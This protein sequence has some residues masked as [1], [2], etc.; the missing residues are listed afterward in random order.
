MDNDELLKALDQCYS[1]L[2]DEQ[3][4]GTYKGTK[5]L[6]VRTKLWDWI[7]VT[8]GGPFNKKLDKIVHLAQ[9]K[10][11]KGFTGPKDSYM[12]H[13]WNYW[14]FVDLASHPFSKPTKFK[15]VTF[16]RFKIQSASSYKLNTGYAIQV[17]AIEGQ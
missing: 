6:E 9:R 2:I 13:D 17:K 8:P 14:L 5:A 7:E 11:W 4:A 12:G 3:F 15:V 1:A 10:V 16:S